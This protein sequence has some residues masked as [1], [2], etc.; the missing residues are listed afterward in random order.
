MLVSDIVGF[1]VLAALLTIVPGLD[2]ALV[3]RS[4]IAS[5]RR[6]GFA[7][8]LGINTGVWTW[9]AAASAGVAAILTA[10]EVAFTVLRFAGAVYL[11]GL[12]ATLLLGALRRRSIH[13]AAS[14]GVAAAGRPNGPPDGALRAWAR[15]LTTNLLNP[16]VGV[17]YMAVLPQ[18]I[19]QDSPHLAVGLLLATIH[20]AEGFAWFALLISG[21]HLVRRWVASS[22]FRRVT[23]TVTGGVLVTLGAALALARR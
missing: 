19:P 16:K 3:L 8:A 13:P 1:A 4:A 15:G 14:L 6:Q 9:G 11:I 18:F 12:G 7:T 21:V 22:A 23:D 10:S 17:F 20:N 2:T 5:G